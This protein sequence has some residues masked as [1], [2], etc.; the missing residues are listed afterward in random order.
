MARKNNVVL[1]NV[2]L[3]PQVIGNVA[4]KKSNI[5]R[6][7]FIFVILVLTVYYINDI[8]LYINNLLGKKSAVTIEEIQ[9]E[10]KNKK[11]RDILLYKL[12]DDPVLA[13]NNLSFNNFI[14]NGNNIT[15][16]IYNYTE[17]VYNF[18]DNYLYFETYNSDKELLE[19]IKIDINSIGVKT[20]DNLK[21]SYQK[22]FTYFNI[23]IK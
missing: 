16:D 14:K 12:E 8:S 11:T 10:E 18:T 21:V 6:V 15:F 1:E 13:V 7:L 9:K 4:K 5:W 23:V 22:D 3:K 19:S 2:E 20:K 17:D